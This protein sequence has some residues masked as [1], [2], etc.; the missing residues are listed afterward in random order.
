MFK[1]H[2]FRDDGHLPC[3]KRGHRALSQFQVLSVGECVPDKPRAPLRPLF[4]AAV[5]PRWNRAGTEET[6]QVACASCCT[7]LTSP[8]SINS[9]MAV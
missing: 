6:P 3:H 4:S 5:P 2:Y 9:E 1:R 8:F 7:V